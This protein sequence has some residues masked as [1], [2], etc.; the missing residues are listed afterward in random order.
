VG[1]QHHGNSTIEIEIP[2]GLNDGDNVHYARVGPGGMDLM[3]SFKIHPNPRWERQGLNL[4]TNCNIDIWDLVLGSD[5]EVRDILGNTLSLA[6][7]PETQPGTLL[8]VRG[9]GLANRSGPPGDLFVRMQAR[10]PP[11]IPEQILNAI[12]SEYQK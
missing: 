4:T 9:R 7:A 6:V 5:I 12:R 1:T 2:K 8:R 3:I 11:N 10:I